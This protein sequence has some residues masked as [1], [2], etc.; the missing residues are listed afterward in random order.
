LRYTVRRAS[1][2]H[3]IID[4]P[5]NASYRLRERRSRASDVISLRRGGGDLHV[6]PNGVLTFTTG[7]PG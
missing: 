5:P 3:T 2:R 1:T 7:G 4:L 6:S